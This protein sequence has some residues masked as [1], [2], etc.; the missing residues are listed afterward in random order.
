MNT[1]KCKKLLCAL[2]IK[3]TYYLQF[4]TE[5]A[6]WSLANVHLESNKLLGNLYKSLLHLQR[7]K[8]KEKLEFKRKGNPHILSEVTYLIHWLKAKLSSLR[9]TL[10]KRMRYDCFCSEEMC[11]FS[12]GLCL[13]SQGF[14]ISKNVTYAS[15]CAFS[16][17]ESP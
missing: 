3:N 15:M 1:I 12:Q 2:N 14:A 8:T 7:V 17:G 6:H 5:N 13:A 16:C 9:S 4:C 11:V 10:R